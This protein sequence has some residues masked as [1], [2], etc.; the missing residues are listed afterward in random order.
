MLITFKQL[1]IFNVDHE[2]E[3][4][5]DVVN[6]YEQTTLFIMYV[7]SI[8]PTQFNWKQC[9]Q[10]S[11][12]CILPRFFFLFEKNFLWMAT[13][14]GGD[15][16]LSLQYKCF[17]AKKDDNMIKV[18]IECLCGPQNGLSKDIQCKKSSTLR[19]IFVTFFEI[20]GRNNTSLDIYKFKFGKETLDIDD[21]IDENKLNTEDFD[22][23][24]FL[25]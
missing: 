20:I 19:E 7:C 16:S 11:C 6:P 2:H 1:F 12:L 9:L 4:H 10:L 13:R 18:K 21:S 24:V 25:I 5:T 23:S 17:I 8:V 14:T 3:L 22:I 15:R